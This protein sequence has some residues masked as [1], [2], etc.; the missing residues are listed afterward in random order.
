[1]K[2]YEIINQLNQTGILSKLPLPIKATYAIK[3]NDKKLMDEYEIYLQ[4]LE[5]IKKEHKEDSEEYKQELNDLLNLD[6]K[7]DV[8]KIDEEILISSDVEITIEQL[9]A[10]EFMLR[11]E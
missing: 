6:V 8:I 9:N 1:M 7:I 3:K 10:L 11:E 2:N 4:L 5:K